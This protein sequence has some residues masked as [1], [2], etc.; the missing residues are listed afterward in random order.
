MKQSII[1]KMWETVPM[2]SES[3]YQN[4]SNSKCE[5][6]LGQLYRV[7]FFYFWNLGEIPL[8]LA[9]YQVGWTLDFIQ[10][11]LFTNS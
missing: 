8:A 1:T 6:T 4:D 11:T 3:Y 9:S 10:L 5:C 7:M 2:M